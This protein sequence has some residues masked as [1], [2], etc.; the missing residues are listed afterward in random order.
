VGDFSSLTGAEAHC[1]EEKILPGLAARIGT[2]PLVVLGAE[3]TPQVSRVLP[4]ALLLGPVADPTPWFSAVRAVLVVGASGAQHWLAAAAMCATPA[5]AMVGAQPEVEHIPPALCALADPATDDLWDRFSPAPPPH[6]RR[7]DV[8]IPAPSQACGPAPVEARVAWQG[9]ADLARAVGRIASLD[10]EVGGEPER[11]AV[12]VRLG[13]QPDFSPSSAARLVVAASWGYGTLPLE[14]TGP[15]RDSVDELWVPTRWAKARA[16]ESGVCPETVRVVPL[17]LD[18]EIFSPEGPSEM[19]GGTKRTTCCYV[20]DASETSGLDALLEA[21][22]L[23]FS[24]SDNVRL[25]ICVPHATDG[26][27]LADARRA[28]GSRRHG[29]VLVVEGE[30]DDRE[31][32]ALYRACDVICAPVRTREPA[33]RVLEAMSCGLPAVLTTGAFGGELDD[34]DAV[35]LVEAA[36]LEADPS[37]LRI[38]GSVGPQS[39]LEPNRASIVTQLRRAVN[40]ADERI[41]KGGA[42]RRAVCTRFSLA[43]VAEKVASS[44]SRQSSLRSDTVLAPEIVRASR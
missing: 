28:A 20:G 33:R 39:V 32:A 15:V 22:F 31:W 5:L 10:V 19:L 27:L 8:P 4:G 41:R 11:A 13:G 29:E 42:A 43:R 26:P 38:T 24:R 44:L 18:P 3:A 34:D 7:G 30:R 36:E 21:F 40:D 37:E 23:G 16:I 12:E 2:L 9:P 25:V 14:W 17:A 1:F 6:D 35:Y